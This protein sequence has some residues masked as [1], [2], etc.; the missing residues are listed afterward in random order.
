MGESRPQ[1][2]AVTPDLDLEVPSLVAW[3]LTAP[4]WLLAETMRLPEEARTRRI[5]CHCSRLLG[6]GYLVCRLEECGNSLDMECFSNGAQRVWRQSGVS[7][8]REAVW[9]LAVIWRQS[10]I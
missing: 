2:E 6:Q 1:A 4:C 8:S 10:R 5:G 9:N 7:L 3:G